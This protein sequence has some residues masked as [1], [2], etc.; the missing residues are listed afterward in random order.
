MIQQYLW[1]LVFVLALTSVAQVQHVVRFVKPGPR[2]VP[3]QT[4]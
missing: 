3:V 1:S 4:R 2:P